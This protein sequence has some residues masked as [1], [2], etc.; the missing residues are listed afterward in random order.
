M[1]TI[2]ACD[3]NDKHLSGSSLDAVAAKFSKF[4]DRSWGRLT[5]W[6]NGLIWNEGDNI[7]NKV[8][9]S[10]KEVWGHYKKV[11][12]GEKWKL[13]RISTREFDNLKVFKMREICQRFSIE[14]SLATPCKEEILNILDDH[15][16]EVREYLMNE[17]LSRYLGTFCFSWK[18][19]KKILL[20]RRANS[21][22]TTIDVTKKG[23]IETLLEDLDRLRFAYSESSKRNE[24]LEETNKEL[25]SIIETLE[26]NSK[27]EK[28]ELLAEIKYLKDVEDK[29]SAS[30][31]ESEKANDELHRKLKELKELEVTPTETLDTF[32]S[33]T[34]FKEDETKTDLEL[35]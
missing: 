5:V 3:V 31:E 13:K 16:D 17:E 22:K 7:Y 6:K 14:I 30:F 28:E 12:I 35:Y 20:S 1:T 23:I 10:K 29:L 19:K 11:R 27:K 9:K 32:E 4:Y 25:F 8:P 21:T 2:Y 34:T 26:K 15:I 18:S 24:N 33:L